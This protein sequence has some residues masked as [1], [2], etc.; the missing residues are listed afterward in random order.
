MSVAESGGGGV[1]AEGSEESE[2]AD[3]GLSG[4]PA[5][6]HVAQEVGA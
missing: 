5:L 1:R 3:E 6:V 4:L 2:S